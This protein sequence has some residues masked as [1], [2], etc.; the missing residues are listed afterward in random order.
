M[1]YDGEQI[2]KRLDCTDIL[3]R[4]GIECTGKSISCPLPGHEDKT[5][6]AA[7]QEGMKNAD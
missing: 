1:K 4:H 3:S 6:K 2:K 5:A 7:A